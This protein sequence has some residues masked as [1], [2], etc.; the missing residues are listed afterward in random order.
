MSLRNILRQGMA[1]EEVLDI[2]KSA[3]AKKKKHHAGKSIVI[4][5][6]PGSTFK[7]RK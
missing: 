1:D 4:G 6:F 3:V 2:I 5:F 7:R